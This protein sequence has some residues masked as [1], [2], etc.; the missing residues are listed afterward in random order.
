MLVSDQDVE[1]HK[2]ITD[3]V[4]A[5]DGKDV[6]QILHTGRYAYSPNLV[7][8]SAIKAPI[9]PFVPKALTEEEILKQIDDFVFTSVQAQKAGY[10]GVEIMGSEGYFIN[11]L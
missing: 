8:P 6:V 11:Q 2:K 5:H 4:H 10:D 7:A 3:A 1:K 9:N